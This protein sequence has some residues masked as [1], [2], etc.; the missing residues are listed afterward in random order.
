MKKIMP[1]VLFFIGSALMACGAG[2]IYIPAGVIM[3]GLLLIV[4]SVLMAISQAK[5]DEAC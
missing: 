4:W 1:D 2:M 5:G 3:A